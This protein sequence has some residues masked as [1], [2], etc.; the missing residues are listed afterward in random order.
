MWTALLRLLQFLSFGLYEPKQCKA[1]RTQLSQREPNLRILETRLIKRETHTWIVAV[2]F[3]EP[4]AP[5]RPSR[6][7]L[8]SVSDDLSMIVELPCGPDSPYWIKGRK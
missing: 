2:F 4:H 5:V 6:Y 8:F 1:A 3:E 7:K